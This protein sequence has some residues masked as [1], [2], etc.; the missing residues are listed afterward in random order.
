MCD[1]DLLLTHTLVFLNRILEL[2]GRVSREL[3]HIDVEAFSIFICESVHFML[4]NIIKYY[5]LKLITHHCQ[6]FRYTLKITFM[7]F[8]QNQKAL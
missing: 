2:V 4:R 8:F 5:I 1:S 3:P 6:C 7:F